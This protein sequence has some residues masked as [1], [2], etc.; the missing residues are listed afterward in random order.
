[1]IDNLINY[2]ISLHR[3]QVIAL[4]SW[5]HFLSDQDFFLEQ[6]TVDLQTVGN[7]LLSDATQLLQ[8]VYIYVAWRK[9]DI[10]NWILIPI[11]LQLRN[12]FAKIFGIRMIWIHR[13]IPKLLLPTFCNIL[14]WRSLP[15][16]FQQVQRKIHPHFLMLLWMRLGH[17][18]LFRHNNITRYVWFRCNASDSISKLLWYSSSHRKHGN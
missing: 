8:Y 5:L 16:I 6:S 15:N 14:S 1:M 13:M 4:D 12:W 18:F 10:Y 11:L 3:F 9:R 17:Y 7:P 2:N